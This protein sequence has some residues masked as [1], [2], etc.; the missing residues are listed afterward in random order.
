M[1]P[2]EHSVSWHDAIQTKRSLCR[3]HTVLLVVQWL[4]DVAAMPM[5]A[6]STLALPTFFSFFLL[7]SRLRLL[8]V[9]VTYTG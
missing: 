5:V 4:G 6:G 3:E 8:Q 2:A 1:L 9:S 7:F